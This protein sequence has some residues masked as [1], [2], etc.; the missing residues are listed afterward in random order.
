MDTHILSNYMDEIKSLEVDI[1]EVK[2]GILSLDDFGGCVRKAS[3][4]KQSV[5]N[6]RVAKSHLME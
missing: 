1:Q 3:D 4:I 2:R 5:F 6:L